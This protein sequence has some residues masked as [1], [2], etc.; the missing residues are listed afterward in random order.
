MTEQLVL[1]VETMTCAGCEE[2]VARVISRIDGVRRSRAD[3]RSREVVV[4]FDPDVTAARA[5][6]AAATRALGGAGYEVL[7]RERP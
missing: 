4:A 5:V 2:R 1:H 3:H 7:E 6:L